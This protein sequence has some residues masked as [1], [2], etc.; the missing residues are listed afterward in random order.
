MADPPATISFSSFSANSL[1]ESN[2][3]VSRGSSGRSKGMLQSLSKLSTRSAMSSDPR[4]SSRKSKLEDD[5]AASSAAYAGGHKA[6]FGFAIGS[7][8]AA[9]AKGALRDTDF[10]C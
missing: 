3:A 10:D 8:D 9:T 6:L 2:S 4:K 7:A 5:G 1:F